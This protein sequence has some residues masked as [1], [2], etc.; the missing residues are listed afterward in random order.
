[1]SEGALKG[2]VLFA[3]VGIRSHRSGKT[4]SFFEKSN[5]CFV[6]Q[7]CKALTHHNVKPFGEI[8][9]LLYWKVSE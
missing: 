4:F 6:R 9:W 8:P 3:A 2:N 1:M 7:G 5:I